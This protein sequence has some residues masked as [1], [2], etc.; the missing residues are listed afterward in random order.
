MKA[1]CVLHWHCGSVLSSWSLRMM[2]G[3]CKWQTLLPGCMLKLVCCQAV[4][5]HVPAAPAPLGRFEQA[6]RRVGPSPAESTPSRDR[7]S[8][9]V[10][11][12]NMHSLGWGDSNLWLNFRSHLLVGGDRT[13]AVSRDNARGPARHQLCTGGC[14]SGT[15]VLATQ[16]SSRRPAQPRGAPQPMTTGPCTGR[17]VAREIFSSSGVGSRPA[18]RHKEQCAVSHTETHSTRGAHVQRGCLAT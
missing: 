14:V 2:V 7:H 1:C 8:L 9:G 6:V 18:A 3:S 12:P 13:H 16:H 17:L 4:L 5:M 10:Q 15:P 11:V